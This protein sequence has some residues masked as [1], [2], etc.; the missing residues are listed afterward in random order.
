MGQRCKNGF[1]KSVMA[2]MLSLAMILSG[3]PITAAS[4]TGVEAVLAAENPDK[5]DSSIITVESIDRQENNEEV[6]PCDNGASESLEGTVT[7]RPAKKN[8]NGTYTTEG[9]TKYIYGGAVEITVTG[10]NGS[11]DWILLYDG[12]NKEVVAN[13]VTDSKQVFYHDFTI[14]DMRYCYSRGDDYIESWR[15]RVANK[16][17][18]DELESSAITIN[19]IPLEIKDL[20]MAG[21]YGKVPDRDALYYVG[22]S[23]RGVRYSGTLDTSKVINNDS[24]NLVGTQTAV[25][26]DSVY[27]VG[28]NQPV[29]EWDYEN[30][31]M[32][33]GYGASGYV[34]DNSYRSNVTI[35]IVPC[36]TELV[37]TNAQLCT[38]TDEAY[39]GASVGI[40]ELA[41][42]EWMK[43]YRYDSDYHYIYPEFTITS[44]NYADAEIIWSASQPAIKSVE[45]K[46]SP[47]EYTIK[48]S[49]AGTDINGDGKLEYAACSPTA[50]YAITV[51]LNDN[52][53][54]NGD[55]GEVLGF[56]HCEQE[57]SV[58][59]PK[60]PYHTMGDE[61]YEACQVGEKI[62]LHV[63]NSADSTEYE[64][65][66]ISFT[67]DSDNPGYTIT[68][69]TTKESTKK[70]K[71]YVLEGTA[72]TDKPVKVTFRVTPFTKPFDGEGYPSTTY[73]ADTYVFYVWV[74]TPKKETVALPTPAYEK[75]SIPYTGESIT[76]INV[77]DNAP[78]QV[79]DT[80]ENVKSIYYVQ[81][82]AHRAVSNT[83]SAAGEYTTILRLK[84][85]DKYKWG[86]SNLPDT[87][88][89]V[90]AWSITQKNTETGNFDNI[91]AVSPTT[92]GGKGKITGL[93]SGMK[94][95]DNSYLAGDPVATVTGQETEKELALGRYW[96]TDPEY[97]NI[98]E[99][100]GVFEILVKDDVTG[101]SLT[102]T[103]LTIAEDAE[104]FPT[105]TPVLTP[106][107]AEDQRV[108][109]SVWNCEDESNPVQVEYDHEYEED[110]EGKM[111]HKYYWY[112]GVNIL[113]ATFIKDE[114]P[115][116]FSGT[117]VTIVPVSA[118]KYKVRA[119][120]AEN[121]T[122]YAETTV[123]VTAPAAPPQSITVTAQNK[124]YDGT[125][126]SEPTFTIPTGKTRQDLKDLKIE[127]SGKKRDN[128]TYGP[129]TT[130]PVDAGTYTATVSYKIDSTDYTGKSGNFT[131][132]PANISRADATI[133]D[134]TYNGSEQ[135][136]S[137]SLK[138]G[139]LTVP[140]TAYTV[141]GNKQKN[142]GSY[143]L[144]ITA[145]DTG[146]YTGSLTKNFT[147]RKKQ[148]TVSITIT[149]TYTFDG[150]AK[151]PTYK[152]TAGGVDLTETDYTASLSNN[153]NAGTATL[154]I[155]ENPTGNYTFTSVSQ[156]F[157][158]A[159]AA[160]RTIPDITLQKGYS[161][162]SLSVP[163]TAGL[164]PSDAGTLTYTAG[165]ASVNKTSGSSVAVSDFAVSS[166]GEIT[167]TI[168]GGTTGDVITLPVTI[169][170]MNY[171]D[172]VVKA[173]ITLVAKSEA[174]ITI[175]SSVI[176]TYG[177][178]PF[179][180]TP[181]VTEPGTG[182]PKWIYES[183]NTAVATVGETTG[184]VTIVGQ[185]SAV[186]T[187]SYESEST[188]DETA[189]TVTVNKKSVEITGYSA[190]NKTYDGNTT[191]VLKG[192][193]I[194]N[195][196]VGSDTVK[197]VPGIAAFNTKNVGYRDVTFSGFTLSGNKAGNYELKAQPAA[198]KATIEPLELTVNATATDRA[199]ESG[200]DEVKI[201]GA[202]LNGVILGDSVA[203]STENVRGKLEHDESAGIPLRSGDGQTVRIWKGLELTG[204][205]AGNY[206][207][208][209]PVT[210]TV[211]IAKGVYN[212]G[213]GVEVTKTYLYS[214]GA[215]ES[216]AL[217]KLLPS[218]SGVV[219][220]SALSVSGELSF[221]S[222]PSISGEGVLTYTLKTSSSSKDGAI[223]LTA[224]MENY[225]DVVIKVMIHQQALGIYEKRGSSYE[226]LYS[227]TLNTGK[228]I[229]VVAM[230][231]SGEPLK[232]TAIW[233]S[234][235]P[236]VA[237]VSQAGKITAYSAGTTTIGLLSEEKSD[238]MAS[239]EITVT[240]AVTEIILDKKS[241]KLG[242]GESLLLTA[243]ILPKNAG[244]GL[245]WSA[246]PSSM[247]KLSKRD[248][249]S[250]YVTAGNSTG[251]VRITAEAAD[252]SGKKTFCTITIG[253]PVG[254]FTVS[255]KGNTKL[256]TAG[257]ILQMDA[258]WGSSAPANKGLNWCISK[259]FDEEGSWDWKNGTPA[260]I[261]NGVLTG[262]AAGKVRVC[263][264]SD[265]K[266]LHQ[267]EWGNSLQPAK[268][269]YT[270]LTVYVPVKDVKLNMTSGTVSKDTGAKDLGLSVD[271]VSAVNG[272]EATGK[273]LFDS[274]TVKWEIG[275]GYSN[276]LELLP[277]GSSCTVK[278]KA[279]AQAVKNIPVTA[280][281]EA[282]NGYK[283]TVTCKVSVATANPF[284]SIKLSKT[285]VILGKGSV[286]SLGIAMTPANPDGDTGIVWS[287]S[288]TSKV[289]VDSTTGLIKAVGEG[290][291]KI[292]ATP[293]NTKVRSASCTVTVIPT[294]TGI[295]I[296]NREELEKNGLTVGKNFTIKTELLNGS[297]VIKNNLPLK[298]S[299]DFPEGYYTSTPT[300]SVS[301]KGKVKGLTE[302]RA[303]I[304]VSL[305]DGSVSGSV[306][307]NVNR[308]VEK[309]KKI[310]LDKTKLT[311][312]TTDGSLFGRVYISKIDPEDGEY[313]EFEWKANNDNVLIQGV[314]YGESPESASYSKEAVTTG[315][316]KYS[317]GY[318]ESG[319]LAIKAVKPGTT[320]IVC[321]AMDGS[322]KKTV[323]TVTVRGSV[324]GLTLTED[325]GKNGI[326]NVTK[327][328][329]EGEENVYTGVLKAGGSITLKPL[330]EINGVTPSAT[331]QK[332]YNQYKKVT[333]TS[334]SYRSSDTSVATVTKSGKIKIAKN[335]SGKT[336]TIF[337]SS[338]DG[339]SVARYV[340]TIK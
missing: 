91:A 174:S 33:T 320:K 216:I 141:T 316:C 167:A 123:T 122:I 191:A 34:I 334:V 121:G 92:Q 235:N 73:L 162:T 75:S 273:S 218:D 276:Y 197:I 158:I 253:N 187:V 55:Q 256:L 254:D 125:A 77:P 274:P 102:P 62:Q 186:I 18:Y 309:V 223:T 332:L 95:Y 26:D 322:K 179:T 263:A 192:T 9:V 107:Y 142:A 289:T 11:G 47:A 281:V 40:R 303:V 245:N 280:T 208:T 157:T 94:I 131:I 180:L 311:L 1:F 116:T 239:L 137:V 292:T 56:L 89:Q 43:E 71:Y 60:R 259:G 112:E 32:L 101:I 63:T 217:K 260:E 335:T 169:G 170:S 65:G 185:G 53:S 6:L 300:A 284:K 133:P 12:G 313:R 64:G 154:T 31:F 110:D 270:D 79:V 37:V 306:T 38:D 42:Y 233:T 271:I 120:S 100:Y 330:I 88:D 147:I 215:A 148:V 261:N 27:Y 265:A 287:S 177:D 340:V 76:Y 315:Y 173:V 98:T 130:A 86:E 194:I 278:A 165:T 305:A 301:D 237:E 30:H 113:E 213:K 36:P 244:S 212:E 128:S 204:D 238:L 49:Y 337:I 143:S 220:F 132:S 333:D 294:I 69:D 202:T 251:R 184:L 135:T 304:T 314:P 104:D 59:D 5:G 58:S 29:T 145:A 198:V 134:L 327:S 209:Y 296:T 138:L 46:T 282:Y 225:N 328:K 14:E 190:E 171:A 97:P 115:A 82:N 2:L 155:R 152:V 51:Y 83:A 317:D 99:D 338:A 72:V 258:N 323:I 290:K 336:A 262:L 240:E 295:R 57:L 248:D 20:T 136:A 257:S 28:N 118:G 149:G 3:L 222:E 129:S 203:V 188:M 126:V 318:E 182:T 267:E 15:V 151:T 243:Q 269:A 230:D 22:G 252:G 307:F 67:I 23:Y 234:T 283:K 41:G 195:G 124:T 168:T 189:V 44:S 279:G 302:G 61:G 50:D 325:F 228:S 156:E 227:A 153:T 219:S 231:G 150:T 224:A 7:L 308:K 285:S 211:N 119:T 103:T 106:S 293:K 250:Y 272:Q 127:Y 25:I 200:N 312:G 85:P 144:T 66:E 105:L 16:N 172:S 181:S 324:T 339:K 140:T 319:Y 321:T 161:I 96:I 286:T 52:W 236:A 159:K 288:D 201:S 160:A 111:Q 108:I 249:T 74:N 291:A 45:G 178:E 109:W 266:K 241:T 326:G 242:M 206:S 264:E 146:N 10:T 299:F 21:A 268:S 78:Y 48:A 183:G 210:T 68:D 114:R 117:P 81:K 93:K 164:M 247:V 19:R 163:M 70:D 13:A 80:F 232:T 331:D 39:L 226:P 277:N 246:E 275:S 175:E 166:A 229:T 35:D 221:V 214:A 196:L 24:V 199:Y 4:G 193:G 329:K 298:W 8:G 176:K 54:Y 207:I 87:S 310:T 255:G 90:W 139:N 297:T 17:E 84:E 205:D